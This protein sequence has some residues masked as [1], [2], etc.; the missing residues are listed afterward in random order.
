MTGAIG[1]I[2]WLACCVDCVSRYLRE[3]GFPDNVLEARVARMTAYRNLY[4]QNQMQ[5]QQQT[6]LRSELPLPPSVSGTA[7]CSLTPVATAWQ[8]P[9]SSSNNNSSVCALPLYYCHL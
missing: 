6:S 2:I 7:L 3:V 8:Q 4:S 1:I 9:S 5:E